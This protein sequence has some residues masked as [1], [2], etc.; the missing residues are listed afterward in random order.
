MFNS[1]NNLYIKKFHAQDL[2][3]FSFLITGGA[4]FIGSNLVEYLLKYNAK[5]VRVLDNLSNGYMENIN[6][7]IGLTNFE[8]ME[9]DIRDYST[10]EK[11]VE[12]I[13]FVSHQ[14]AL[15]SIPRSIADPI[16]TNQVNIDGFLNMLTVVKNAKSVKRFIYAASSSTY[17][18][19]VQLPKVEGFEGK[20]LS[21]YA[22]TKA[23]N[24]MYASVFSNVY[25]IQT[26]GLR[27]FNVFG[28]KQNPDNPYAA[29]IPLFLKKLR[30]N[31]SPLIHGDGLQSRDF[32]FV[33][34][35]VKANVL[36]FFNCNSDQKAEVVNI[37]CGEQITLINLWNEMLDIAGKKIKPTFVESRL[38]DVKHSLASI[39]KANKIL[40]Y[41]PEISVKE[42]LKFLL[43]NN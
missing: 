16:T 38:G 11:A 34:N 12:G 40:G 6:D 21:P 22:V 1:N 25:N 2:A 43:K 14:A 3:E 4:G 17:G 27:Y 29:V 36:A 19:S 35:V 37:A 9:G 5:K 24:E 26:V 30:N 8:F 31:E 23:V 13:D 41:S 18:D 39:S 7:F 20:P 10:C 32:T 15:G 42:G 28:P 33:S